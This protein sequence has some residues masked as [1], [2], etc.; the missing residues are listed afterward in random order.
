MKIEDFILWALLEKIVTSPLCSPAFWLLFRQCCDF[1]RANAEPCLPQGTRGC[2]AWWSAAT[3]SSSSIPKLWWPSPPWLL[4]G[5]TAHLKHSASWMTSSQVQE[6]TR[7]AV[8]T[9]WSFGCRRCSWP[10]WPRRG[11][12]KSGT[13][14]GCSI[15]LRSS[16]GTLPPSSLWPNTS[17]HGSRSAGAECLFV[18]LFVCSL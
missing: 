6:R 7:M 16:W 5:T 12:R 11:C 13:S 4:W 15:A 3:C 1:A 8:A 17:S 2:T 18:C 9:C 10:C 14:W